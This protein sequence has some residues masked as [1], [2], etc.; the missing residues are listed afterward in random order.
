[1]ELT[2]K[3]VFE[4]DE[5]ELD[6][7]GCPYGGPNGGKDAQGE[8]FAQDT[9]FHEDKFGLPP[10][11]YY[12]GYGSD[13][14]PASDPIFIGRTLK[15]WRDAA[16]E[17]FRVR[18]DKVSAEAQRVWEAAKQGTARASSGAVSHLV[19]TDTDG[20]IRHWPVAELSIFETAPGGK[21]PANSYAVA[22]IAAKALWSQ[23]GQALPEIAEPT[24]DVTDVS[25]DTYSTTGERR[26]TLTTDSDRSLKM[27]EI[28]VKVA[29]AVKA[30]LATQAAEQAA[31]A[32]RA[33][34]A[35]MKAELKALQD[36]KAAGQRLPDGAPHVAK[37]ADT[38]KFDNLTPGEHAF[39]V[40]VAGDSYR[41]GFMKAQLSDAAVRG[42]ALKMESE[43]AKSEPANQGLKA[44]NL[45]GPG[46]TLK[47]NEINRSTLASFGDE[48]VGVQYSSELWPNIRAG[49]W[50]VNNIPQSEIPRGY[51]SVIIPLEG[52]DPVWY[53]VAQAADTTS[54]TSTHPSIT[55][56]ASRIGT[57]QKAVTVGKMG[58]RVLYTGE[59]DEDSLIPWVPNAMRQ[60]Q[61]SGSEIME[62]VCIDGDTETADKTNINDIGG[63]PASTDVFM[64]TNGFRKL[65]LITNTANSRDGGA[66]AAADVKSTLLLMGRA[67]YG[68]T[69]PTKVG[70]I[71]DPKTLATFAAL[72]ELYTRDV[73]SRPTLENGFFT[74]L[75]IWNYLMRASWFMHYSGTY[76]GGVT[77]AA[78]QNL[79][80]AAGKVDNNTEGNNTLGAMLA[81]RWD[82]WVLKWKRRM[83]IES[84]RQPSSD[85]TEIV[86]MARWGLGYRDDEAAAISYNLTI[87]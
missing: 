33:E 26:I 63:T 44:F 78:Y 10:A 70:L 21:Q 53:K 28:D 43:A 71:V 2:V 32:E 42:L 25:D 38:A 45:Y 29:E 59:M 85:T 8:F 3:A 61:A 74:E 48:W 7:L 79:A 34:T 5:W 24:A 13:G 80:N 64:L 65:P 51:E 39:L 20:H 31:E 6:V 56:P 75:R 14:K 41:R 83:T 81:V 72:P 54:G 62:F 12:H 58:C 36:E 73:Y 1:M 52:T 9:K 68:A 69:D 60:I 35:K 30:A 77:T 82:Q 84:T 46:A 40:E 4:T 16:G 11:V 87:A 67:G 55:I 86:A 23:A 18:L 76:L 66:I 15:R 27:D 17:W 19:R 57:A 47:A 50:V 22:L 37:F 49:S